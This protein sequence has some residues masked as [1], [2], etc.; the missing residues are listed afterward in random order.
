MLLIFLRLVTLMLVSVVLS[1][2]S[3]RENSGGSRDWQKSQMN[4]SRPTW[5][6]D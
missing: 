2:W 5:S 3:N 4:G 6:C 1:D